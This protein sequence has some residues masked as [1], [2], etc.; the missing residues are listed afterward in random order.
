VNKKP[1]CYNQPRYTCHDEDIIGTA[2][3]LMASR[4]DCVN[5]ARMGPVIVLAPSCFGL[6]RSSTNFVK[7][8]RPDL[9]SGRKLLS[10]NKEIRK[11]CI[12][13]NL[14]DQYD[15]ARTF[16]MILTPKRKNKHLFNLFLCLL[17]TKVPQN[18]KTYLHNLV[19]SN[20]VYIVSYLVEQ[21]K[22]QYLLLPQVRH[23]S[24]SRM[25]EVS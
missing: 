17:L 12:N 7:A 3:L 9:N 25:H 6:V 20:K 13:I 1:H 14:L 10:C 16:I 21:T 23:T 22:C 18:P 8:S 5:P 15:Y 2:P 11:H 19:F 4:N 24:S